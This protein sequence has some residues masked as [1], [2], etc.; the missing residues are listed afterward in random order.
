[1]MSLNEID[2]LEGFDEDEFE[3]SMEPGSKLSHSNL[4]GGMCILMYKVN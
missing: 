4:F 3:R 1:M 2:C